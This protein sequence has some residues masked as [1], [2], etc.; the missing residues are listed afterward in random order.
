M[1]LTVDTSLGDAILARYGG[2]VYSIS[3]GAQMLLLQHPDAPS[4]PPPALRIAETV[5]NIQNC[6]EQNN[7]FTLNLNLSFLQ[8][9]PPRCSR[10]GPGCSPNGRSGRARLR[11]GRSGSCRRP[12]RGRWRPRR[13]GKRAARAP[14]RWKRST[15]AFCRRLSPRPAKRSRG[16]WPC[17]DIRR[18]SRRPPDARPRLSRPKRTESRAGKRRRTAGSVK[19]SGSWSAGRS[20]SARPPPS[21]TAFRSSIRKSAGRRIPRRFVNIAFPRRHR[22][23]RRAFSTPMRR[24]G[25]KADRTCRRRR[26]SRD[27][28]SSHSGRRLR[29]PPPCRPRGR[30]PRPGA[31]CPGRPPRPLSRRR[32]RRLRSGGRRG[33]RARQ[34]SPCRRP[35]ACYGRGPRRNPRRQ[36]ARRAGSRRRP[37]SRHG[38]SR[39]SARS[40]RARRKGNPP[41]FPLRCRGPR[42]ALPHS[43]PRSGRRIGSSPRRRFR[44]KLG[45]RTLRKP[46][47]SRRCGGRTSPRRPPRS[48]QFSGRGNRRRFPRFSRRSRCAPPPGRHVRR[49][50]PVLRDRPRRSGF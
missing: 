28:L 40:S 14:C 2:F 39:R 6:L 41:R 19:P 34:I 22:S 25:G 33:P 42:S 16:F 9:L 29:L 18:F 23:N 49:T 17:A 5:W 35:S 1:L 3:D 8:R 21:G 38:R 15:R 31:D 24:G 30:N 45:G 12:P 20:W 47:P 13:R 37:R 10:S 48:I 44:G 46:R 32:C 7:L 4:P 27:L 36:N 43:P 11:T 50:R 26:R